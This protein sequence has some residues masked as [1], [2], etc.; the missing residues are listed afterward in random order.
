[1]ERRLGNGAEP[2]TV[3]R[4]D[5]PVVLLAHGF[6]LD[7]RMWEGQI[8][9]LSAQYRVVAPDLRGFGASAGKTETALSKPAGEPATMDQMADDLAALL[10]AK[11]IFEPIVLAGLSMGGYVALSFW[12][13]H[14]DRLRALVLCD[15]RAE[16]DTPETAAARRRTADRAAREGTAFL[17]DDMLPRLLAAPTFEQSPEVVALARRMILEAPPLA[18]A[19]AALGMAARPDATAWLPRIDCPALLVV[20][21]EDAI[22]PP[23]SMRAMARS[24]PRARVVEIPGAGHLARLER[25]AEFNAALLDFLATL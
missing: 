7:H 18:V 9:V 12:R 10:D 13:R 2:R 17:C 4:G 23:A 8:A 16:A 11:E 3:D 5:G 20:G 24:M 14:A 1:M 15:T 19:A 25:P 6:P 21:G 22:T